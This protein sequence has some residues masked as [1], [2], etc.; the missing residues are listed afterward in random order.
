MKTNLG[1]CHVVVDCYNGTP[2]QKF[3]FDLFLFHLA[4]G[5]TRPQK[6][7][8]VTLNPKSAQKMYF[9]VLKVAPEAKFVT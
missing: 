7:L 4:Q 2:N 8:P 6:I 3:Y 1:T 9:T 5:L